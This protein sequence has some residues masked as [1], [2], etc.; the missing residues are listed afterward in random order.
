MPQLSFKDYQTDAIGF[1]VYP[2]QGDNI[3]YPALGLAGESGEVANQIKKVLRDD[4]GKVTESRR[5]DVI[6]ELGDCL[7][8]IANLAEELNVDIETIAHLNIRKL[9]ERRKQD[10]IHGDKRWRS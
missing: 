3:V 2:S 9:R 10:L 8:Y 5:A 7:W 4:K 1:A 6:D